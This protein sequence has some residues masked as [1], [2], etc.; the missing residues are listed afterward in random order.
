MDAHQKISEKIT[1]LCTPCLTGRIFIAA[2]QRPNVI[3]LRKIPANLLIFF[4][5]RLRSTKRFIPPG[6]GKRRF[7]IDIVV[8]R[9][10]EAN[11]E[12]YSIIRCNSVN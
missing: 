10:I 6:F 1:Q 2:G 12:K 3:K 11:P 5:S 9:A 8:L 4:A 7:S